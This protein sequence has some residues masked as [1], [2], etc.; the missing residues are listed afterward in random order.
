M[1]CKKARSP[2][3]TTLLD[4]LHPNNTLT[5]SGSVIETN[6]GILAS[7]IPSFKS[8]FKR[9][10]P[11]LIGD[12]SSKNRTP[13]GPD[14]KRAGGT[15]NETS[16]SGFVELGDGKEGSENGD[17]KMGD[18]YNRGTVGAVNTNIVGGQYGSSF[19]TRSNSSKE[20]ACFFVC[21]LDPP[22][23]ACKEKFYF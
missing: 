6:I 7:S 21:F 16:R 8:L 13:G 5:P 4:P 14:S 2:S 9:Y 12:C 11:H 10:L 18:I 1:Y 23:L 17:M 15:A 19:F 22:S 20:L 3:I